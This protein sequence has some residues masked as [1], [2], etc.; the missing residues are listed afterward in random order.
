MVFKNILD[1]NLKM[2]L[3]TG[4]SENSYKMLIKSHISWNSFVLMKL[5]D[6]TK[7]IPMHVL[8]SQSYD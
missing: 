2:F 5:H 7:L 3:D 1:K 6:L 4:L 8:N